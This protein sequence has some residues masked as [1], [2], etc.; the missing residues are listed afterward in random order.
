MVQ[1]TQSA[2]CVHI[3]AHSQSHTHARW[4]RDR[5]GADFAIAR[6]ARAIGHRKEVHLDLHPINLMAYILRP[7]R[8]SSTNLQ[9]SRHD[10]V[11]QVIAK[12]AA[13]AI[14][15]SS[16]EARLLAWPAP[17]KGVASVA[18]SAGTNDVDC[19]TC[20]LVDQLDMDVGSLGWPLVPGAHA[21]RMLLLVTL[22]PP[23]ASC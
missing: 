5:Y 11:K 16:D 2:L 18:Q 8:F 17:V 6:E 10:S 14:V 22:T 20:T 13:A 1:H 9:V 12:I 21:P 19:S 23:F 4:T 15:T 7:G 3:L